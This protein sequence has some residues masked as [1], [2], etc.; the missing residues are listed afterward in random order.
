M[1]GVMLA[2]DRLHHLALHDKVTSQSCTDALV[3]NTSDRSLLSHPSLMPRILIQTFD[4]Q[5]LR[6]MNALSSRWISSSRSLKAQ[7]KKP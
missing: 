3:L 4:G 2:N 1:L 7:G 6:E 5:L